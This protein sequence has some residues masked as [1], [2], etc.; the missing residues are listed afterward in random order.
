MGG[1]DLAREIPYASGP[2]LRPRAPVCYPLAPV[3]RASQPQETGGKPGGRP[4]APDRLTAALRELQDIKAALDEHSIVGI[5]DAAGRI[6]HVNDKFCAISQYSREELLGRDHRVINSGTHPKEFFRRLWTTIAQGRVWHGEI[7][8]RAKDGTCYWVDT[9]IYPRLDA[10]GK[11]L[12]YIAIRPDITRRKADEEQLRLVAA[13]L[14][15]KNKELETI[16]YTVSHD[17]RSPLVNVQ[18]F[19]RQLTR[20]CERIAEAAADGGQV[21][22]E[23]LKLYVETA[24]PQALSF[25]NAGVMKMEMLLNGLLRFSRLGRVAFVIQPL[26]MNALVAEILGT[27]KFQLDEAGAE[28]RTGVLPPC[29]G[30]AA[31]TSQ[32]FA[33]LIDN[34]VKYRDRARP[35]RIAI[36]GRVEDGHA[37]YTVADNGIGIDPEHQ[38]KAFEIFHRL[39]PE[40]TAGE[41]L[42]LTIAQRV[43]ERERGKICV[44]SRV[45]VGSTF[46]VSLPCVAN[47]TAKSHE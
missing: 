47:P 39:D 26:D 21:P 14:A 4:A 45:G 10:A 12:Q 2:A 22:A 32:V 27:M 13:D 6:T 8:N 5:T 33:N 41:G 30:D 46:T 18:G 25:I 3:A 17:L 35:L 28:V 36:E 37:A 38:A 40:K 9:T 23:E 31:H 20:A 16:V 42:G 7:R 11:P 1:P 24:I 43:L 44:D 34:A 19:S 15:E 29:L